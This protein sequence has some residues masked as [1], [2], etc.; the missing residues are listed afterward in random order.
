MTAAR[1]F[2][3]GGRAKTSVLLLAGFGLYERTSVDTGRWLLGVRGRYADGRFAQKRNRHDR[4]ERGG[5]AE[6]EGARGRQ[7]KGAIDRADDLGDEGLELGA[8]RRRH[9][10]ENGLPEVADAAQLSQ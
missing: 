3:V 10:R 5:D 6:H 4:D 9:A 7:R 2:R 1:R 8:G